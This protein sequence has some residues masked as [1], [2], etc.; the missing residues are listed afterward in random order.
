MMKG[1]KC[2][3][4]RDQMFTITKHLNLVQFSFGAFKLQKLKMQL[5]IAFI[6]SGKY[7]SPSKVRMI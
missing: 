5:A 3:W 1:D 7:L 6:F 4:K 2:T